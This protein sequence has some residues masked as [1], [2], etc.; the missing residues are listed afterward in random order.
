M[1]GTPNYLS[2]EVINRQ[3]YGLSSDIWAFGCILYACL[4]GTPP[5]ESPN[6]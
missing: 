6:V 3:P 2:P 4:T 5:F 1:C